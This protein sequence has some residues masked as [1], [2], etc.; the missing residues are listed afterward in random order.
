MKY[1]DFA[2]KDF[3]AMET[4]YTYTEE[5][6][7]IVTNCQQ[8]I[9]KA[10]KHLY[11]IRLHE[12]SKSH[13]LVTLVKRLNISEILI[14]ENELRIIQDYYFD[15]RYPSEDYIETTKE[16]CD[17]AVAVTRKLKD[18]IEAEIAKERKINSNVKQGDVFDNI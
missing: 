10:L 3:K 7:V 15:K 16:E 17:N 6:D 18:I 12:L 11:E 2:N 13:K 4:M 1:I 14:Y 9:E 8:Y 5:Y